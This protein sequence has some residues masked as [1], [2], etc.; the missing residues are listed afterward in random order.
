MPE[1]YGKPVKIYFLTGFNIFKDRAGQDES[2][3]SA[4]DVLMDI[5]LR[6]ERLFQKLKNIS[7]N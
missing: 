2:Y 4:A 3:Q 5:A 7:L 6:E 1:W